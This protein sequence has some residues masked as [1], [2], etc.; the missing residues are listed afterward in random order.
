[1]SYTKDYYAVL[2]LSTHQPNPTQISSADIRRAYKLALLAA[3]PD[4][5]ATT[6]QQST[7]QQRQHTIDSVKEAYTVLADAERKKEYDDWLLRNPGLV[8]EGGG[9]GGVVGVK[10]E[11]LLGL[12]V[13]D[14]S[15]FDVL[16]PGFKFSS[17]SASNSTPSIPTTI[18]EDTEMDDGGGED[19][20][21]DGIERNGQMEWTRA[22][23]C[24][25][26]EGYKILEEELEDAERRGETEVLV[27]C[28]GCSLWVRVGFGSEEVDE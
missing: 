28:G 11:F 22:C 6:T 19:S 23:R 5:Q 16:D 26:A 27:G 8:G 12:E 2:G 17:T 14:L 18:S 25:D 15:D 13:L 1:M 9:G 4:K 20:G 21:S 10:E 24:G 3:H 7:S